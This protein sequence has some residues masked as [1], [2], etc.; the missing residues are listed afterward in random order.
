MTGL[1]AT[2]GARTCRNDEDDDADSGAAG[3]P[4]PSKNMAFMRCNVGMW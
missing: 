3:E 1:G 2:A 4:N